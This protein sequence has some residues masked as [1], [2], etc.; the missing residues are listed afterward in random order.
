MCS[1]IVDI[2]PENYVIG[3]ISMLLSPSGERLG[4][5]LAGTIVIRLD[6]PQRRARD[7][8]FEQKVRACAH[9]RPAFAH[10]TA[11]DPVDSRDNSSGSEPIG[12]AESTRFCKKLPTPCARGSKST[13][14]AP[15]D[16][17]VFLRD[18]LTIAERYSRG[19]D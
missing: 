18:L 9:A 19:A 11:R 17:L 15:S 13:E 12:G 4:D 8:T 5:H 7:R 10:R 3:L 1:R 6:R 14:T 2:L 16:P